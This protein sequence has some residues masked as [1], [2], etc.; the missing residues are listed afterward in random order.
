[1][2]WSFQP[3]EPADR[4]AI[5]ALLIAS[6]LPVTDLP[7]DL[8]GF[9]ILREG[10]ILAACGGI[11]PLDPSTGLVRSLAVAPPRRGQGIADA[12]L[13][14]LEERAAA[15]G[16]TTLCMLTTTITT[17]AQAR[18]YVPIPRAQAPEA[19]RVTAQFQGLCPDSAAL[20]IKERPAP[21]T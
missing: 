2:T 6:A 9:L 13:D 10:D 14:A 18:G 5:E 8:D 20:L 1:M 3:A 15:S 11:E 4:S 21:R 17:F 16:L 12:L 7:A 19:I